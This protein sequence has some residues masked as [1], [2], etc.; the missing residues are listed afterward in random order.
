MTIK[1]I[2]FDVDGTLADTE[3]GHRLSFNKAFAQSGLDW[4]WDVA[5]YDKLLKVTGGKERIK[6]FI[7]D[8]LQGFT[9]PADFD[10][11]V[12][13][14]HAVKTQHYTTMIGEGNVPLRPGIRQ[15]IH[16]AHTAGITL[17]I[18]TTTTPE[19]VSALLEVGLGKNWAD[20]FAANGCGDI[21]P[22]K[23]PAPDIYF[24]VLEKLGL[25]AAECIALE[26][27]ENGLRSS[28]AAGIRTYVTTNH[29]TRR[30][31]FEGAAAVFDD[32]SNLDQFYQTAG[33]TIP[34]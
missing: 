14:L 20:L 27:S 11:F 21:V 26:D 30:Q 31:N 10:G 17:A 15:L 5:L 33:L 4:N 23:K 24:W 7:S 18:A 22:H 29:Y 8:F 16:E 3:D 9:K 12:K 19:N 28:L 34:K 25:N 6:Y 13:N 32:L 1:A 2:I